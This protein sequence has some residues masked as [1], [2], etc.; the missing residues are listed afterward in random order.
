M[1]SQRKSKSFLQ[2]SPRS[3]WR[4]PGSRGQNG[5]ITSYGSGNLPKIK[6]L[7][8]LQLAVVL[9]KTTMTRTRRKKSDVPLN[10]HPIRYKLVGLHRPRQAQNRQSESWRDD[11]CAKRTDYCFFVVSIFQS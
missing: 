7:L 8:G 2:K 6:I 5:R 1:G 3:N 9:T 11:F 4:F 10:S